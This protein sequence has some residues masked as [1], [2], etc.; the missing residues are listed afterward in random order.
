[1]PIL[2]RGYYQIGA[3]LLTARTAWKLRRSPAAV[4][5]QR[6]IWRDLVSRMAATAYGR[7]AGLE[8]GMSYDAFRQRVPLQNYEQL[9]P[10][11]D[12]MKRGEAD[13]LW[14]GTCVLFA[15]SSGTTAG[16]TKYLPVTVE[17][18]SHFRQ[19]GHE[20]L[21]Y[22]TARIGRTSVFRGR[23]LYLGGST[24]LMP[25]PDSA[26]FPAYSGDLS[27]IAALNLPPWVEKYFYEPGGTIAQMADWPAKIDA[28]IGR[29]WNRD[30]TLLAGLPTW[31][32]I[33]AERLRARAGVSQIHLPHLQALW[34]GLECLVHGGVPITPF[35]DE[36]RA[37]LGPTVN[38]HEIY[39]ASE[40]FIAAQDANEAMG[41]RLMADAGLFFE[42]LPRS[43]F[44]ESRLAVLGAKAVP[45][46]HVKPGVDYIL[47]L[48]TPAG[49]ARYVLGDVV[50][51]VTTAPPR[52]IYVGRTQLQLSAF[53][54]HVSEK[55]VT[56]S[57]Q[58]VCQRRG[59]Q[60]TTFHVAPIF[61]NSL[62]GQKRGRHE[63]WIELKPSTVVTPTGPLLAV[64][65]DLELQR[66]NDD[67]AARRKAAGLE[68]P[69]VR[70]VIPGVFEH[71]MREHNQWGGQ[72]K[73]PRCRS[74]RQVADALAEL[75]KFT[76]DHG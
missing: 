10:Y 47:L 73:M 63:W 67:Y 41:L 69:Y 8:S 33:L 55:E 48:T 24:A 71:W 49:L 9:R 21:L 6:R 46:E 54:E 76:S 14:P 75:T 72:H 30:I 56:D 65:L 16:R 57:L 32:L 2:P 34:P 58:A 5:A 25:L 23:H 74:D 50:R 11:I 53:G 36:L 45:L 38:F 20:S 13:V 37:M 27:G 31:I 1:M 43:E 66:R 18:L 44:D 3:A 39:A 29:T 26:P 61:I 19:T 60:V 68:L 28:I 40:G 51:F 62:T 15:V 17:M 4:P 59:W 35:A 64:E 7:A 42:F 12:R 52:L 70:L 22:Y